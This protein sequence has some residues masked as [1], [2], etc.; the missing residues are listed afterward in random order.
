MMKVKNVCDGCVSYRQGSCFIDPFIN[1]R[2]V[3]PCSICIVKMVCSKV[4][5]ELINYQFISKESNYNG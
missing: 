4:C 2:L 3:C 5:K 1:E